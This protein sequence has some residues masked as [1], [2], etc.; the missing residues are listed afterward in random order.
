[1]KRADDQDTVSS[2]KITDY[3]LLDDGFPD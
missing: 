3:D 1:M 2:N